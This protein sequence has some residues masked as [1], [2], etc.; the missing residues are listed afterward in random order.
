MC[1]LQNISNR[2]VF[3]SVLSVKIERRVYVCL[4]WLPNQKQITLNYFTFQSTKAVSYR[5]LSNFFL[6]FKWNF[7]HMHLQSGTKMRH[8]CP[9]HTHTHSQVPIQNEH[10][11][12]AF[13]NLFN[14][15]SF[16]RKIPLQHQTF[17]TVGRAH[18]NFD[19][20][21][22]QQF[23]YVVVFFIWQFQKLNTN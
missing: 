9:L 17:N 18:N 16:N 19:I 5:L 15:I 13:K 20:Y 7:M 6:L 1:Y 12:N 21:C 11:T 4:I 8:M 14:Y 22:A 23:Q 3:L 10:N 2:S